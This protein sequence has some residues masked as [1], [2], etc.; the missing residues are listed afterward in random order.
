MK[1]E[2]FEK[3]FDSGKALTDELDLKTELERASS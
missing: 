2:N 1:A 3:I